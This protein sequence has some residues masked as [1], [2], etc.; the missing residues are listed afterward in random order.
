MSHAKIILQTLGEQN[1]YINKNPQFTYFKNP[2]KT[3][4]QFGSEWSIVSYNDRGTNDFIK[5]NTNYYFRIPVN[6]DIVNELYL[7]VKIQ[8]DSNWN[9]VNFSNNRETI[10]G[11]LDKVVL[12]I[13]DRD[14]VT[15]DSDFIFAYLEL[16][17]TYP[18]KSN[19]ANMI[20]YDNSLKSDDNSANTK[21]YLYLTLPIPF[22]FHKNPSNGL[23]IWC[24]EHSNVGIKIT[25]KNYNATATKTVYDIEMLTKYSYLDIEE[26]TKFEN[27]PLEY[28]LEQPMLI[29]TFE[30]GPNGTVKNN[31]YKSIFIKYF[32]WFIEDPDDPRA[33]KDELTYTNITFNGNPLIDTNKCKIFSLIN[34]LHNFNSDATLSLLPTDSNGYSNLQVDKL[35]PIYTYSF[36]IKP[37]DKE[38]SGFVSTEKYVSTNIDMKFNN[39]GNR[40]VKMY[41]VKYN[42]ARIKENKFNLLFN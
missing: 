18:E 41:M 11:I 37:M 7:R 34:R 4:T 26:K 12:T 21:D 5:P 33:Y 10:F 3:H 27:L 31:M 22:W 1:D 35:N 25:T 30:I 17:A 39:S 6:G 2:H 28:V 29:G 13:N 23:P 15:L 14:I 8:K 19:L 38:L 24:L 36:A 16:H 40:V 20:S 42:I 9:Y 32:M